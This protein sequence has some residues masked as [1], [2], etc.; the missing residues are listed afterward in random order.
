M[1]SGTRRR[2]GAQFPRPVIVAAEWGFQLRQSS[3]LRPIPQSKTHP[4]P[5]RRNEHSSNPL[6]TNGRLDAKEFRP[7]RRL[8]TA[9]RDLVVAVLANEIYG[10]FERAGIQSILL[11]GLSISRW[12]YGDEHERLFFDTDFIVPPTQFDA[13][14]DVLSKLGFVHPGEE[15]LGDRPQ[16]AEAWI[17]P[18]DN[19][20]VDLHLTMIG[21]GLRPSKVWDV[22]HSHT[23]TMEIRGQ[24]ITILDA[25]SRAVHVA[26][27]AAQAGRRVGQ[28]AEDLRRAITLVP[29]GTWKQA[30]GVARSLDAL[31]A[32]SEGLSVLPD[33]A[34]LTKKLG[35]PPAESIEVIIRAGPDPLPGALGFEWLMRQKGLSSKFLFLLR[36]LVPPRAFMREWIPLARSG[37]LGLALAYCWRP[38]YLAIHFPRAVL[39]WRNANREASKRRTKRVRNS[40]GE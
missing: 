37:N 4:A 35:I 1:D 33:G 34:E 25:P 2:P 23:E 18:R 5:A 24:N 21:C 6:L 29:V 31:P 15:V 20:A 39:V 36:K 26:L 27:H 32:M 17:R 28:Q 13:A 16:H 22:L 8:S 3:A 12:L 14:R 30:L 40:V 38:L 7:A 10:A 9:G 19:A 11:K